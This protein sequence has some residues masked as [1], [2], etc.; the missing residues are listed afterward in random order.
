[1]L[2]QQLRTA[3]ANTEGE[4]Q[5]C[6]KSNSSLALGLE[7]LSILIQAGCC[8]GSRRSDSGRNYPGGLV[9]IFAVTIVISC[10]AGFALK[11]QGLHNAFIRIDST[12]GAAAIAKL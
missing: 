4:L 11:K 8:E 2:P 6:H 3:L 7:M 9:L 5:T 12:I 10:I 1:V